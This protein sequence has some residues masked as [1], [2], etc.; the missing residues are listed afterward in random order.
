MSVEFFL[1]YW[2][3]EFGKTQP[4]NL[5][6][7]VSQLFSMSVHPRL[8]LPFRVYFNYISVFEDSIYYMHILLIIFYILG[9]LFLVPSHF[10]MRNEVH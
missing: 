10:R 6:V 8:H 9:F 2:L 3:K 1:E 7:M 4:V 5:N